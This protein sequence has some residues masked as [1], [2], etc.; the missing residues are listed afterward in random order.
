MKE[1]KLLRFTQGNG[2]Q[3]ED[4]KIFKLDSGLYNSRYMRCYRYDPHPMKKVTDPDPAGQ[5]S[6]DQSGSSSLMVYYMT[7]F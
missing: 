3:G 2:I 4:P 1:C 5:K 7:V 6:T